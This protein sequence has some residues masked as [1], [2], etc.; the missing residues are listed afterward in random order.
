MGQIV[1]YCL[2]Y[3]TTKKSSYWKSPQRIE[4]EPEEVSQKLK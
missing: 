2:V 3:Y 1:V 4:N